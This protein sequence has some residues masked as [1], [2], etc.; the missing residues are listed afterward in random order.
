[1]LIGILAILSAS[2]AAGLRIALP[3]LI[4]GLV[5]GD[6]WSEVP[7]LSIIPPPLLLGILTSWSLFELLGSKK[8]L[9][10]R[11]LQIIQLICSPLVGGF[12]GITVVKGGI[13]I[14]PLPLWFTGLVGGLLAGV[15]KLVEVG[16]FFRLG[17]LPLWVVCLEDFICVV[18]VLF[19]FKAPVNGGFIALMLLWLALRSSTA[20]RQWQL[21]S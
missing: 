17:G 15:L 11:V 3:L 2:A 21:K 20:W 13:F 1:M 7:L 8:L 5:R 4:I 12:L 18:L 16:W 14:A 19:A 6:L 9:G 10:Q